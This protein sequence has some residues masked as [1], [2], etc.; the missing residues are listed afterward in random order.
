[1]PFGRESLA[2]EPYVYRGTQH[3]EIEVNRR[4]SNKEKQCGGTVEIVQGGG[5]DLNLFNFI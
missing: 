1:M 4:I 5:R 3:V 2:F